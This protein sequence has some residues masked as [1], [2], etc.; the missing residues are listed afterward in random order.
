MH[1]LRNPLLKIGQWNWSLKAADKI[2]DVCS[3]VVALPTAASG[4]MKS[5]LVPRPVKHNPGFTLPHKDKREEVAKNSI[6]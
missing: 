4:E 1:L 2:Y 5:L 6:A 3:L